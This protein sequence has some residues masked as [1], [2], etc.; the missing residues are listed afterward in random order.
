MFDSKWAWL[1]FFADEVS[2]YNGD[3]EAFARDELRLGLKKL[4]SGAACTLEK[5]EWGDGFEIA[6]TENG[7]AIR[8]GERGLLYGVYH[9]L[10][11]LFAKESPVTQLTKPAFA[12]RMLNHWDNMTG[13][14]ERGYAGDSFF[15][16]DS[17][18]CYDEKCLTRY[19]RLLCSIG[20]NCISLN[21][22]NVH[23]PADLL[24]MPELLPELKKVAAIFRPFGVR[25]L[26][27]I[28]YS[29]PTRHGLATADPLDKGVQA[30]W[31]ETI[32]NV[33][34]EIADLCG[35][36]VKA[37]SENR[38]GPYMYGRDHA[39]GARLLSEPLKKH[40][41]VLVWRCF[42]YNCKQD[43]RDQ[44][45][46]RVKAAYDNYAHL[47]G[48]FDDNVI[49]QIKNG[50]LDFQVREPISPLLYA[51]PN[52]TKALELQL[53]QEYTGHAIDLFYMAPQWAD[54]L[55]ELD[56]AK[57]AHICAVAN[58]G[59]SDNW[60]GHDLA[61][62]NLFAYGQMAW[63]GEA[64]AE[65][66]AA[67]WAMLTYGIKSDA[68]Q[69]ML[70]TSRDIYEKYTAPLGTCFMVNVH[71][72]YGPSPE[73]YEYMAWGTYLRTTSQELGL[74]RT[75]TGTGYALQY[76]P[77]IAAALSDKNTCN[78]KL[79]L[80]FH[81][82]PYTHRM[83]DG[84]TVIQR[85]YDD[86]FEGALEAANLIPLWE[87]LRGLVPE[88]SYENVLARLKRQKENA[89]EWRDVINSYYYRYCLIG[90]ERGRII[91]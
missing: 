38:P 70:L 20:I 72:H 50:P 88:A 30:W 66:S 18:F 89:K 78:E 77:R 19:A 3:G 2:M 69:T 62:A 13:K 54:Y 33:Y 1:P 25:L 59:D 11:R 71:L 79:L 22:V 46:D 73:G 80:F 67:L 51:M 58:T 91:Y 65:K 41:G 90:D 31:A 44:T 15:F 84:R 48:A 64:D 10:T 53:A 32:D 56:G 9:L 34:K 60:T 83:A 87:S 39:Q 37:D 86:H 57:I 5:N 45:T 24:I 4:N 14:I 43:W 6:E 81:R 82:V 27:S 42:V 85:I 47:D 7:Y 68:L 55:K 21:N 23:A 63:T 12:L 16:R 52:T 17:R 49:L 61:Q 35:F 40:G 28:D 76:P 36:L 75:Q 8:G 29:L 26:V 74:D